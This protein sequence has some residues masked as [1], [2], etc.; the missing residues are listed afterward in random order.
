[1]IRFLTI[2][3]CLC[4]L[5]ACADL[6]ST[7][8]KRQDQKTAETAGDVG[9]L[10]GLPRIL[11]EGVVGTALMVASNWHGRRRGV[12]CERRRQSHPM[13]PALTPKV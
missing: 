7:A 11:V 3:T 4:A 9:S 1:M 10:F 6:R 13:T 12:V 2:C 8:E 5:I